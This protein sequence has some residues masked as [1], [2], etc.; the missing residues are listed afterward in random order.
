MRSMFIPMRLA[1]DARNLTF[2]A[3][4][5]SDIDDVA[6]TA[7]LSAL[8]LNQDDIDRYLKE[9][10]SGDEHYGMVVGDETRLRQVITNLASN[11]CKFTPAGGR[12]MIT[13]RLV[14]S[15]VTPP[16]PTPPPSERKDAHQTSSSPT[17]SPP[18]SPSSASG[19]H[20]FSDSKE[21]EE[22]TVEEHDIRG[23]DKI[24][25]RIE[26]S[27]TGSGIRPEDMIGAKLF[28]E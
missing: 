14:R 11:A 13:T 2:H 19:D 22:G 10:P 15:F 21:V 27:D 12:V 18:A 6:R 7:S 8:G 4:L 25:V 17:N 9:H 26:V 28:C 5:D 24:I 3:E 20:T 23:S 16:S 1:T